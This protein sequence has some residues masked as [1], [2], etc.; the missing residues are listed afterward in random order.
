MAVL[1]DQGPDQDSLYWEI[2]NEGRRKFPDD[3]RLY[4]H[5]A[6]H[7]MPRWYGQPGDWERFATWCVDSLPDSLGAEFYSRIV[8]DQSTYV[9]NVFRESTGLSWERTKRGLEAWQRRRPQ[10]IQPRSALAK[11]AW[12]AGQPEDAA[13]AFAQL[14][15]T[16][17]VEIWRDSNRFLEAREW[18]RRNAAPR[19]V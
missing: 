13:Q 4:A 5:A 2:F 10:S 14:G 16:C 1:H 8:E 18:A 3:F 19:R 17:E 7:L 9:V 12:E 15:D 6:Y 11:L